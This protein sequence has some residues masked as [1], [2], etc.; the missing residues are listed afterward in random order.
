MKPYDHPVL[1][2]TLTACLE[3]FKRFALLI[4]GCALLVASTLM[5]FGGTQVWFGC[6]SWPQAQGTIVRFKLQQDPAQR[7]LMSLDLEYE[8]SVE[9]KRQT[10]TRLSPLVTD[11]RMHVWLA[12]W[13]ER[14]Y[15]VGQQVLVMYDRRDMQ[16][17]FVEKPQLVDV[18]A[19]FVGTAGLG[20]WMVYLFFRFRRRRV[21]DEVIFGR[22]QR[23]L[24]DRDLIVHSGGPIVL[25]GISS[26]TVLGSLFSSWPRCRAALVVDQTHFAVIQ[27]PY[28]KRGI[29]SSFLTLMLLFWLQSFWTLLLH[30][31]LETK[32]IA[33]RRSAWNSLQAGL[34]NRLSGADPIDRVIVYGLEPHRNRFW[35]R[36]ERRQRDEF[37][38]IAGKD[39]DVAEYFAT[40]S[41]EYLRMSGQEP[42]D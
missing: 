2:D 19:R 16:A 13:K 11:N 1:L 7:R 32:E 14:Q 18:L 39:R 21:P 42:T 25:K 20:G 8:F 9:A 38:E 24:V 40:V 37:I 10:G 31:M 29:A 6:R 17:S 15:K 4:L 27:G 41:D 30:V 5:L 28:T 3:Q 22:E 35:Y 12:R 33:V 34:I 36:I 26:H 23:A